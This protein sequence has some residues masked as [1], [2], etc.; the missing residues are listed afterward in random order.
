MASKCDS[1]LSLPQ[2]RVKYVVVGNPE[3]VVGTSTAFY[4]LVHALPR[5][6]K[7]HPRAPEKPSQTYSDFEPFMIHGTP[8]CAEYNMFSLYIGMQNTV[9]F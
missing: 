4:D 2:E 8:C 5:S 1:V 3:A 7:D 6:P 9:P